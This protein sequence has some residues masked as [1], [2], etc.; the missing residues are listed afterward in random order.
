MPLEDCFDDWP[1]RR[2]RV[3]RKLGRTLY[4]QSD[5]NAE[6]DLVIGIVDRPE[7]AREIVKRWNLALKESR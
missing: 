5:L 1:T 2:M 7:Y 6:Q 4:I 3:G